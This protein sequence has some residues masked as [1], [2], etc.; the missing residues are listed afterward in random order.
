MDQFIKIEWGLLGYIL[1]FP[2]RIYDLLELKLRKELFFDAQTN[3]IFQ[4][5]MDQ[6]D[7]EGRISRTKLFITAK[8][9]TGLDAEE[10]SFKLNQWDFGSDDISNAI[11]ELN[12]R[13]ERKKLYR[14]ARFI[15]KQLETGEADTEKL[16]AL[17]EERLFEISNAEDGKKKAFQT[18]EDILLKSFEGYYQRKSKDFSS[19]LIP[20]GFPSLD[21]L[22]NF[23]RGH[24][25]VLAGATSMGK[26]AFALN[27]AKNLMKAGLKVGIISM[28][29]DAQEIGDRLIISEGRINGMRFNRGEASEEEEIRLNHSIDD[30][31]KHGLIVSDERGLDVL[32]IKT[33]ARRMKQQFGIGFLIVDYLQLVELADGPEHTPKKVGQVV[34]Q[35]RNLA[36]ELGIPVMLLSQISREYSKRQSKR[37]ILSDLR[38]SGNIEEF[39]DE[40]IFVYRQAHTSIEAREKARLEGKENHAEIIVAKARTGST[41]SVTLMYEEN[42]T[43]F[44]DPTNYTK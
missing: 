12:K 14:L 17:I 41:G 28:E 39:S 27:V 8:D 29:M 24:L 13:Y 42:Y 21:R 16:K 44:L 30:L 36:G 33:K 7:Y 2:D 10:I 19:L 5:I 3:E 9:R 20:T 26:T 43:L 37:P 34:L 18:M 38:D 11:D 23:K 1:E 31:Y 15:D 6:L 22:I 25:I 32:Q 35:L 40:V 4:I